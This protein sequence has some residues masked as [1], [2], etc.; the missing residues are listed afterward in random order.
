[1]TA[2][3]P[4]RRARRLTVAVS[5]ALCLAFGLAFAQ[6]AGALE[7]QL[8]ASDGAAD[9]FLGF[10][11]AV[12]GDTAVVGAP[13]ADIGANRNQ[14]AV[15]VF[16][17]SGDAW[18]QT[19]KLTASE[20]AADDELGESV[21]LAGDTIVAGAP[22]DDVAAND[23]QGSVYAFAATGAA[24]RTETAK[25]TASDGAAD[26]NLGESV[27]VAGD[28]VVAGALFD[29][30]AAN[31]NQGSVYVFAATGAA[32]RTETAKLTASDGAADDNLGDSVAVAGDTVVAG[33][34][35]ADVGSNT[36]QG[37][38]YTFAATGAAARTETVKLTASDGAATTISARRWRWRATRSWPG[39]PAPPSVPTRSR[40]R[41]TRSP[42]P[43]PRRAGRPPSSPP[44][45]APRAPGSASP[46]RWR[47]TRSWPARPPRSWVHQA[48][49]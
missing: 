25:L 4:P 41:S 29:D 27:A 12:A 23:N 30:V 10:S 8:T 17:R 48:R 33:A 15:Y 36:D 20:G 49:S 45:M 9:D 7:Q 21:A 18:T 19:A 44:R 14:G 42:P 16:T 39:P 6:S 40:A 26:D 46:W 38:V 34:S 31:D 43:G 5:V 32:V 1:M 37:S 11:V 35:F 3:H 22:R 47:A 2:I 28:T 24:A 13:F